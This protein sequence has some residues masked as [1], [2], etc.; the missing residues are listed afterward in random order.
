[1][2]KRV[3]EHS[4]GPQEVVVLTKE[5]ARALLRKLRVR[6]WQIPWIRSSD[7]LVK[8]VGAKPGDVIKIVRRSETAGES[9]IYRLVVPG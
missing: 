7:P 5:E 1:M 4:L 8:A 6:P 2:S 9:V 3:L